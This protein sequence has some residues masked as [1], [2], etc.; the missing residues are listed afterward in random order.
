VY[1]CDQALYTKHMKRLT[2]ALVSLLLLVGLGWYINKIIHETVQFTVPGQHYVVVLGDSVASGAGLSTDGSRGTDGCDVAEVSFPYLLGQQLHKPVQQLACSGAT[3][4]ASQAN[5]VLQTQYKSAKQFLP[6]SDVVIYAGANDIGWLTLLSSC[7]Q[8][9]C[10]TDQTRAL[11]AAKLP[12]LQTDLAKLLAEINQTK[13]N[14]VVVNT[15]YSLLAPTDTCLASLG[16]S[17]AE[18]GFIND[19]EAQFNRAI[20]TTATQ[21]GATVVQVDFGGHSL[22][23]STPWIQGKKDRAP[24]HPN[25][26]G[27]QQIAKQD[28]AAF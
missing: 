19:A 9:N 13:P 14:R 23:S 11:L 17:P 27:Q 6:G 20:A 16:V 10:A 24:L 22:C 18:V 15:Y 28:F 12:A 21:A 7:T 8:T 3:I 25:A 4:N 5:N 1:Y 2:I 26:L